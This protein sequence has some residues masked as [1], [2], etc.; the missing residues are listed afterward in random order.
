[1]RALTMLA[2]KAFELTVQ[3]LCHQ[4]IE[5]HGHLGGTAI[6]G[7]QPR[8]VLFARRLKKELLRITGDERITYGE[9]DITFHR[10]DFRHRAVTAAASSTQIDFSLDGRR[11]VLVDDVLHTGRTIRAG[12][13]ALLS[14]GR[15]GT[16]QLMVL[17]DRRFSRELPIQPD[18]VGKW[19]DSIDGQRVSVEWKETE[20][21]DRVL[22][23][24]QDA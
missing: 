20:G 18:Y 23:H 5:D 6:I 22:L 14:F 4:L 21:Q 9:L 15:P 24:T 8:G 13:D 2:D 19:V 3:R 16:V 10:D 12:L 1:M 17:I 7:L 11:V